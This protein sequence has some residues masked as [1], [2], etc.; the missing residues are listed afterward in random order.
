VNAV[1]QPQ[2]RERDAVGPLQRA[3]LSDSHVRHSIESATTHSVSDEAVR[4][5]LEFVADPESARDDALVA[6]LE[7]QLADTTNVLVRVRLLSDI[8]RAKQI[9]GAPL[10][11]AFVQYA[12]VW[13]ETNQV[14][15]NA[16]K[17]MGVSQ[18]VLA[19]AGFDLGHGSILDGR[20]K[21]GGAG[22]RAPRA[23]QSPSVSSSVVKEWM[24]KQPGSF[25][26]A[27]AMAGA[28]A[29]M[30]T[31][32]KA[33]TELVAAQGLRSLGHQAVAGVRGRAPE[34]FSVE[35]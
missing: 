18:V 9:D 8:E 2:D 24:L 17:S 27:Q 25:T 19:Q 10:L 29:S 6:R 30:M 23:P 5:Y 34:H 22:T 26:I 11:D 7:A 4:R 1:E 20:A 33:A 12:R 16:F 28:G 13:A 15:V 3:D 32:K 14:T 31:V 35:R 21:S